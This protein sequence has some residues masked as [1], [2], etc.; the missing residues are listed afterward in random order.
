MKYLFFSGLLMIMIGH[1]QSAEIDV[2][3]RPAEFEFTGGKFILDST[4]TVRIEKDSER[5][6]KAADR[7]LRRLSGRTGL[8][9]DFDRPATPDTMAALM[10]SAKQQVRQLAPGINESYSLTV[11]PDNIQI[12]AE[13]DIG[14]LYALETLLQLLR[15]E[16]GNY[17]FPAVQITDS[18]RFA[19][20][21]LMI[22]ASRHFMPVEVIKRNLDGM[23][24]VKL[25]VFHWHLSDDQG[26]R[27]ESKIFPDLQ[28][29]GSD[30]FYYTRDQVRDIISYA[31]ERGIRVVPE[32]DVPGHATAMIIAYPELGSGPPPESIER[33]WG[34]FYQALNP[35]KEYTYKFLD[36]LF[37]EMSLLFPDKY[38]H[39]GGDELEQE[40]EHE[41]THWNENKGIQNFKKKRGIKNNAEL[42][43][44][45]NSR[46]L[47]S[48]SKYGKIMVGW[49]EIL[50]EHMPHSIVIQSWRGRESMERAAKLGY[51]SILSNGYYI[52]LIYPASDHY[53]ND[54]LPENTQLT[55]DQQKLILGGEA[56]MWAEFVSPETIDS[57]IWPRS[58]AIAER[59][60]S[61]V[62]VNDVR[63]MYRRLDIINVLLE[64]QGLTHIRNREM[65]LRR[66]TAN[67]NTEP[68][69]ILV[70]VIEPLKQYRRGSERS[71]TSYSPLTRVADVAVPDA[72]SARIFR[73]LVDAYI[74]S[75]ACD[76]AVKNEIIAW[77]QLWSKN[78][79]LLKPIIDQ[80][81]ILKE[82]E[83]LSEDLSA[84]AKTG[85]LAIELA[86][87]KETG[88]RE[89]SDKSLEMI[90]RAGRYRG[91]TELMI[92]D[93]LKELV[94]L[95]VSP[96]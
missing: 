36:Q 65:M 93:A 17:C 61:P 67:Q 54:P 57:R 46:I 9:F 13:T 32:F 26:F 33:K 51:Q 87:K 22:D 3:P 10:I 1:L 89:W 19:W 49:D 91:Q 69:K 42:Q 28:L 79:D 4:F 15:V 11:R 5:I 75:G 52:D 94:Q 18:P 2:L 40:N 38:F 66:L 82:I 55:T 92:I 56:T 58:A 64:E 31:A 96:D 21:G 35:A 8:F 84:I 20:R 27:V 24:A 25:N 53:L 44:Y 29:K 60:W 71:Y 50:D 63:D 43:A 6:L 59:F 41:A 39:I 72:R 48:L 78:H 34:I 81:P 7:F 95:T 86:E 80:S 70:D 30:G 68:L 73:S 14:A 16:D 85:L 37:G 23:V 45:F 74:N 88:E 47:K 76:T 77:L 83:T 62:Y 90:K 12:V